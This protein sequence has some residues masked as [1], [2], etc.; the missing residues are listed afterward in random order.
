M[1]SL[2][3]QTGRPLICVMSVTG[4]EL[5]T[6]CHQLGALLEEES[7]LFVA[8][9]RGLADILVAAGGSSELVERS[10]EDGLRGGRNGVVVQEGVGVGAVESHRE[11]ELEVDEPEIGGAVVPEHVVEVAG[12]VH[13][14]EGDA[15]GS[16]S[17]TG[18]GHAEVD[19]ESSRECGPGDF[20]E[21]L[22]RIWFV[23]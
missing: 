18:G 14:S 2:S 17:R 10:D 6:R 3:W 5:F 9:C 20:V 23:L 11:E 4:T 1:P 8:A 19:G 15:G 12:P 21:F 22:W 16:D 7:V 13:S